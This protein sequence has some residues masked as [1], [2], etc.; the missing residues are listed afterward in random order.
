MRVMGPVTNLQVGFILG[1]YAF[2]VQGFKR[3]ERGSI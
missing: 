3:E 2:R 1:F